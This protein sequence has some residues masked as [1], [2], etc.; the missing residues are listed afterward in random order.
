MRLWYVMAAALCGALGPFF[1]KQITMDLKSDKV[2]A[3]L[4]E[5]LGMPIG[6]LY[7]YD[8]ICVMIMISF[9]TLGVEYRLLS[10]KTEGAFTTNGLYFV[11]TV[12]FSGM[13]DYLME[14]KFMHWHK[15][16]GAAIVATGVW[17]IAASKE[18]VKRANEDRAN[19]NNKLEGELELQE[20][21]LLPTGDSAFRDY[22]MK[23]TSKE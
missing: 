1:V 16:C 22:E 6:V 8:L 7:V 4:I 9:N 17:F 18:D 23:K 12:I 14:N 21:L 13:L 20:M 10:F 5:R 19:A 3:R 15:Y 11:M 2:V